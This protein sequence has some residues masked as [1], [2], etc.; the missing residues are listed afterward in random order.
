MEGEVEGEGEGRGR[1][2]GE[3]GGEGDRRE[4]RHTTTMSL[5][6]WRTARAKAVMPTAVRTPWRSPHVFMCFW[7]VC[8]NLNDNKMR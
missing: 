3:R 1:G 8:A 6:T 7:A 4:R 2:E 5:E